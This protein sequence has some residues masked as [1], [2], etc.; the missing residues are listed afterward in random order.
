MSPVFIA[1]AISSNVV[2]V[3]VSFTHGAVVA[4]NFVTC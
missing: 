2:R 1:V 3:L 4:D